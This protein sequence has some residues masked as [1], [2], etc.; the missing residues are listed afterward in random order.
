MNWEIEITNETNAILPQNIDKKIENVVIQILESEGIDSSGEVSVLF[1]DDATI[2][3]MNAKF[4]NIDH[5]T[6]VLSFPQYDGLKD[7]NEGHDYL[8][9]GDIV[10]SLDKVEEQAKAF[11]HSY[12][13]ELLYLVV[14]ST[15]HLLG[16]D[17]IEIEDQVE[18]RQKEKK[19]FKSLNLFK[20]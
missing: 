20:A 17:H 10:I 1:V 7:N 6:D 14:H 16:Y 13:R 15:F 5:A 18:M 12:E 19:I 9:L 2:K 3:Q 11:E 4:R 8:Y